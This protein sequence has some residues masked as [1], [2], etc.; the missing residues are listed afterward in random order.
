MFCPKCGTQNPEDGKFCRSCGTDIGNVNAAMTKSSSST[1]NSFA[2]MFDEMDMGMESG[3]RAQRR[4]LARRKDPN[5]VYGDSIRSM[6]SGLGFFIVSMALLFTGVAGGR[7]WW[8]A[9]LFPAFTFIAKGVADHMKYRKMVQPGQ[10]QFNA[11]QQ[12]GIGGPQTTTALPPQQTQFV[13][14]E[15]RYKTGDLVPPS[16]TDS[17]TKLLELEQEGETRALPKN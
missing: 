1:A 17:T 12:P 13:A 9:M 11:Y 4:G 2:T 16:V 14:P 6:L 15:S 7:N 10:T 8:W 5:E 3:S